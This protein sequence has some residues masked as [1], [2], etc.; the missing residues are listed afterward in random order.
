MGVDVDAW[1]VVGREFK[2]KSDVKEF[3]EDRGYEVHDEIE[4]QEFD[5]YEV[6]MVNGYSSNSP[7]ILGSWL[8]NSS[9]PLGIANM[10]K[11]YSIDFEETFGI[12]PEF[13]VTE[14]WW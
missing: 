5:T 7:Y 10:I 6:K 9:S 14:H 12:T 2:S 11:E 8:F 13:I 1:V 4:E 3:L